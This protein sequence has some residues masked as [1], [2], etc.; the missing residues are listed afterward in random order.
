MSNIN[1]EV[2]N[3]RQSKTCVDYVVYV[4]ALPEVSVAHWQE[5][6]SQMRALG[7]CHDTSIGVT[8]VRGSWGFF[9]IPIHGFPELKATFFQISR[10]AERERLLAALSEIFEGTI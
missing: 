10:P 4:H 6:V 2:R 7:F 8:T 5:M 1:S 9:Q 3:W